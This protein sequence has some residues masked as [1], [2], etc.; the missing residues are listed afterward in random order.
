MELFVNDV[1]VLWNF[2]VSSV[3]MISSYIFC[4][5]FKY[6]LH[7]FY[8]LPFW[9]S[10]SSFFFTVLHHFWTDHF[11]ECQPKTFVLFDF[12]WWCKEYLR[13][14]KHRKKH[15]HLRRVGECKYIIYWC[16]WG[17]WGQ[18][19]SEK[20]FMV[21]WNR[22]EESFWRKLYEKHSWSFRTFLKVHWKTQ[23]KKFNSFL[24]LKQKLDKYSLSFFYIFYFI[25]NS[26]PWPSTFCRL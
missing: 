2:E 17:I 14:I 23:I 15:S 5:T 21:K 13:K 10:L 8:P 1:L 6:W 22:N 25:S 3:L 26:F 9:H 19:V 11:H 12:C 24:Q 20:I 7:P 4:Y 18:I 16:S